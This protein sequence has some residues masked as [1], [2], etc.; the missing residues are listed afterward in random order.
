MRQTVEIRVFV[1]PEEDSVHMSADWWSPDST[2]PTRAPRRRGQS[3]RKGSGPGEMV[4]VKATGCVPR[5]HS[6]CASRRAAG[7]GISVAVAGYARKDCLSKEHPSEVGRVVH[8]AGGELMPGALVDGG[9]RT[10]SPA[11]F[12]A[13]FVA[14]TGAGTPYSGRHEV[15]EHMDAFLSRNGASSGGWHVGPVVLRVVIPDITA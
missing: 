15:A 7:G 6:D 12:A 14:V 10:P 9:I 5:R 8:S 13:V 4:I 1:A 2:S 11:V 3:L